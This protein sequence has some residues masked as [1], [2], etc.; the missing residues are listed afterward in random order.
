[1]IIVM[2]FFFCY[3]N[4]FTLLSNESSLV[5]NMNY[6]SSLY[7]FVPLL[8]FITLDIINIY[9]LRITDYEFTPLV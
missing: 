6:L 8:S 9:E 2:S 1:M 5:H 4:F 3:K 7:K